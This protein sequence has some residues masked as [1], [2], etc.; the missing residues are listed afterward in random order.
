[1]EGGECQ[2]CGKNAGKLVNQ[3]KLILRMNMNLQ[4]TAAWRRRPVP[5]SPVPRLFGSCWAR[6]RQ[7]HHR[8]IPS[9]AWL[10][11]LLLG[12]P[13]LLSSSR[14]ASYTVNLPVGFTA[15]ANHLAPG[16]IQTVLG[17][18]SWPQVLEMQALFQT[19]PYLPADSYINDGTLWL[20][21]DDAMPAVKT[22]GT[23]EGMFIYNPGPGPLP[24]TGT[25]SGP[26]SAGVA[27]LNPTAPGWHMR[28][29]QNIGPGTFESVFGRSPVDYAFVHG[30][31][32]VNNNYVLYQFVNSPNPSNRK[33][34]PAAPILDVGEAMW[35]QLGASTGPANPHYFAPNPVNFTLSGVAPTQGQP[36]ASP[37]NVSVTG[38][39]F[40]PGDQIR[41]RKMGGGPQTPWVA[42]VADPDGY[43]LT[44]SFNL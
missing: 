22:I 43:I 32:W 12:F 1:M 31:R 16:S 30:Q 44:S 25:I 19:S 36:L 18:P 14:A 2:Q 27:Q 41:L 9:L 39:G 24:I 38:S 5:P 15:V 17:P 10:L 23:G 35:F 20:D 11:A 40:A 3:T 7:R 28:G 34:S 6:R 4:F 21:A 26:A 33:W 13:A 42:G 37:M 29:R 8:L